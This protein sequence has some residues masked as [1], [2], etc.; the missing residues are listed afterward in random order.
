MRKIRYILLLN[1]LFAM[2]YSLEAQ[3]I[4]KGL[5][6]SL[7]TRKEDTMKTYV[8]YD[9]GTSFDR[10]LL[11]LDTSLEVYQRYDPVS[12]GYDLYAANANIGM[13]HKELYIKSIMPSPF[14]LGQRFQSKYFYRP[15]N[16]PYYKLKVPYSEVNYVMGSKEENYLNFTLGNQISDGLYFGIDMNVESG[17]GTFNYQRV[18]DNH[19]RV[20]VM[21]DSRDKRYHLCFNYIRNQMKWQENGGLVSDSAYEDTTRLDRRIL[22]VQLTTA[23]NWIRSNYFALDQAF[24]FNDSI[25]NRGGVALKI[26]YTSAFR[27][28]SDQG[29]VSNYYSHSF[30]DTNSTFDS[31][32][33][34]AF[35]AF[36]GWERK[37]DSSGLSYRIGLEESYNQYFTA[38]KLMAYTYLVPKFLFTYR[39]RKS[40]L[41][42]SGSYYILQQSNSGIYNNNRFS[43]NAD[44]TKKIGRLSGLKLQGKFF[45]GETELM[46]LK[47]FSNHYRWENSFSRLT[48]LYG[49][50][51]FDFKGWQVSTGLLNMNNYVYYTDSIVPA[52]FDGAVNVFS[53]AFA[54]E[55]RYKGFGSNLM[56]LYQRVDKSQVLRLPE[57]SAKASV[58]FSFPLFKG[59]LYV[60]PGIDITYLSGYYADGYNPAAMVFFVQNEKK[61]SDQ[62]YA[63]LFVNFKIK[64][65]RVFVMYKNINMLFGK[66]NYF[67]ILH[68]PQQDPGFKIGISWRFYD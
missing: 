67:M 50:A 65:A 34:R 40:L 24:Y 60:H 17:R 4:N 7:F 27:I 63:D 52:Q 48:N 54:K 31:T 19:F 53:L 25:H 56:G 36:L 38:G 47:F 20:V 28:Y 39:S 37:A 14:T 9:K 5:S 61:I 42:F 12:K 49:N 62:F 13:P 11:P 10:I 16:V 58:F 33:F 8:Y 44:F 15:D 68:Y 22:N 66:Y 26:N 23:D 35:N 32:N 1:L 21:S 46:N 41:N 18:R 6:D 59:A 57:F 43:L 45:T 55:L 3:F 51:V 64:R 2:A 29:D 30:I